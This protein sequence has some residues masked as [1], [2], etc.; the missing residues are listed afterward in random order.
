M[1]IWKYAVLRVDSVKENGQWTYPL[2][3]RGPNG[4]E[5]Q[6]GCQDRLEVLNILGQKGWEIFQVSM[7]NAGLF[8]GTLANG[9]YYQAGPMKVEF[10]LKMKVIT[11]EI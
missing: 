5:Q 8:L 10:W 9:E 6:V 4:K 2:T 3:F 1:E 7:Q 11:R